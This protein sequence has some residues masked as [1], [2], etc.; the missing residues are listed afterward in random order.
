M[1]SAGTYSDPNYIIG[2]VSGNS[3]SVGI[4]GAVI[5]NQYL[6]LWGPSPFDCMIGGIQADART[7]GSGAG[8]TVLDVLVNGT[9]IWTSSGNRPTLAAAS[10][11]PFTLS[12]PYATP[13]HRG[14]R[15]AIQVVTVPATSG[16]ALVCCSVTLERSHIT[17]L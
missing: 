16:H 9:S 7:A 17:G 8:N 14:D 6:T 15:I 2:V 1:A 11:G 3:E 13:I 4:A 5:A 12:R 10:T